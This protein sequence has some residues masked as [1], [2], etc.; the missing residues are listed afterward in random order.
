MMENEKKT[1]S[2]FWIKQNPINCLLKRS[3]ELFNASHTGVL[4]GTNQTKIK[5]LPTNTWD[6]GIFEKMVGKGLKGVALNFFAPYIIA[7]KKLSPVY[8]YKRDSNDRLVENDGIISFVL[9]HFSDYYKTGIHVIICPD[10]RQHLKNSHDNY[11]EQPFFIYDGKTIKKAD[12]KIRTDARIV[13]FFDSDNYICVYLP[14]Y[15]VLAINQVDFQLLALSNDQFVQ[16]TQL[17]QR[18]DTLI[19]LVETASLENLWRM[20]GKKGAQLLWQKERHL[21]RVSNELLRNEKQY[22]ELYETAPVSYISMDSRGRI[23][24]CNEKAV[25]LSGYDRETLIGFDA[26]KLLSRLPDEAAP[27][28]DVWQDLLTGNPVREM[29]M[30]MTPK[31]KDPFYVSVSI[32]AIRDRLDE[33]LELRAMI[34][35]ISERKDLEKQLFHTQKME[36]IGTL[37]GGLAHDFNNI[38]SPISGYSEMLLMDAKAD[39]KTKQHLEII[40]GCVNHAKE[41]VSRILTFS[42]QKEHELFLVDLKEVVEESMLLI[43]S[44]LP[45]TIKININIDACGHVMADPSQIHQVIMNLVANAQHEMVQQGGVITVELK[46]V[47]LVGLP[48]SSRVSQ[49]EYGTVCLSVADNG[50]GIDPKI[51]SKIF[52]PYFSTKP[53]GQ[54]SGIGLSIVHGIVES[55]G[56]HIRVTSKKDV[57]TCFKIY[58]PKTN[59]EKQSGQ[60]CSGVEVSSEEI[61]FRQGTEKVLL[62]DDDQK[63]ADMQQYMFEKMGYSVTTFLNSLEAM[64]FFQKNADEFDLVVTD[65]SMDGLS[66][67]EL[68]NQIKSLKPDIPVVLC[69]GLGE[70][71]RIDD[72]ECQSISGILKKPISVKELSLVLH[73]VLD[74]SS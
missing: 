14:D 9:R 51:I 12:A 25:T 21:R 37:A 35:D 1:T 33:Q 42:K 23:L 62:V 60:E 55:H 11:F 31:H 13:R 28:S 66:G 56:G 71:L 4:Y 52:D 24:Y 3:L 41:L 16:E 29:E 57:G 36:T 45:S 61:E 18:M 47:G 49:N 30:L 38:L 43:R 10:I 32:E 7:H 27:I 72:I 6:R 5:Y 68:A 65:L 59:A 40:Q 73:K 53:D 17:K 2:G 54:G 70:I 34:L 48:G 15:G 46:D 19:D 63:V 50:R 67:I 44:F 26:A 58:F 20:K 39:N 69:S 8:F 64:A 74:S 22:R